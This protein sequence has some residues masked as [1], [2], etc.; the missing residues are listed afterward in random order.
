MKTLLDKLKLRFNSNKKFILFL[1]G[2]SLIGFISGSLFIT[3][4]SKSDQILVKDYIESFINNIQNNKLDYGDTLKNTLLS[5]LTFIIVIWIL[6]IAVIG[7]PINIFYYFV[8]SFILGFSISAIIL[9]YKI[10]G[11]LLALIYIFPHHIINIFIYTILLMYSINFSYKLIDTIV[12]KK[13]INFKNIFNTYLFILLITIIIIVITSLIEVFLV[14]FFI[15]KVLF[16][17]K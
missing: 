4:I 12:K 16:L 17:I 9:K 11:C 5:N 15:N 13:N 1:L 10:K 7:I 8:K 14:P 2:I 6:G 3:I